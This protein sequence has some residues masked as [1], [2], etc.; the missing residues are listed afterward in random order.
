MFTTSLTGIIEALSRGLKMTLAALIIAF[1]SAPVK[2]QTPHATEDHFKRGVSRYQQRDLDGAIKEFDRAIENRTRLAG[3]A[4]RVR[5]IEPGAAP[6]YYNRG[7]ARYDLH[8]W[9]GALADL[10]EAIKLNPR[11][12]L[13]Y[14]KRG[15]LRMMNDAFDEAISDFSQAIKLDPKS[16]L[17]WNN[18]GLA[19]QNKRD[20]EAALS[21]YARALE[22]DPRLTGA[23]N[24]RAGIKHDQGDLRGALEEYNRAVALD[25]QLAILYCNRGLTRKALGDL[26][27]A[28]ADYTEAIRLR[29]NFSAAYFNR[30]GAWKAMGKG[31]EAEQDF[32]RSMTLSQ[33]SGE[34]PAPTPEPGIEKLVQTKSAPQAAP[35][36]SEMPLC[37]L[38]AQ[39][40]EHTGKTVR[41]AAKLQPVYFGDTLV[42]LIL[43]DQECES[44]EALFDKTEDEEAVLRRLGAG[45]NAE[46]PVTATGTFHSDQQAN[47]GPFGV[48]SHLLLIKSYEIQLP[49]A[50]A[51]KSD[52]P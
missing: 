24:N 34:E 31:F 6:L 20:F 29:P 37:K 22:L 32:N 1:L 44:I 27:G 8:D 51:A 33:A 16:V 3:N 39:A 45:R 48:L 2:A 14:I 17:A 38:T 19:R 30:S 13:A 5:L 52:K 4:D 42:G 40:K 47:Y 28:I 35:E 41:V 23:L 25:P 12:V 43:T 9:D 15:N 21:D 50:Q 46:L 36:I 11:Y 18:R 26:K 10:N 49:S 7:I